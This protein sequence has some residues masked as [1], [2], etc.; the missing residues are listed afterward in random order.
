MMDRSN[1]IDLISETYSQDSIGQ[2]VTTETQR[3]VYC[4]VRS[5][6]KTEWFD[7][8]KDG[9]QPAYVFVMFAPDYQ[10]EKIIEYNGNRYGVY[11]TYLGRNEQIE[12][13]VEEKG[14]INGG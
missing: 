11:R 5:I 9:M 4:D 13:Y 14:G 7:A 2:F 1:V 6:T 12:I 3:Q 10:G 8:G